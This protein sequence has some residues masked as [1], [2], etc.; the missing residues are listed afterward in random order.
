MVFNDQSIL[1]APEQFGA[2]DS[3]RELE[4]LTGLGVSA[5]TQYAFDSCPTEL[6]VSGWGDS[7]TS[8]QHIRSK[9]SVK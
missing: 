6:Y 7:C 9:S 4:V 5:S 1:R 2:G 8:L 3:A